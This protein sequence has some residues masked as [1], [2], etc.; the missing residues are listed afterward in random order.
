VHKS[1]SFTNDEM[2]GLDDAARDLRIDAL[3]FVTVLDS[4]LRLFRRGQY[5]PYRGTLV[6]LNTDRHIL[7]TRGSVW[8]YET[9]PGLYLPEP[10]ELRIVR[11]DESPSFLA[12]EV[13]GLTKLNWNNTQFD[14]KYPV[15]LG[16]ARKVGQVLK[17]LNENERTQS[18]YS[19][20]M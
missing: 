3:D 17:Y 11:S 6:S 1:S 20:Y 4:K 18:R 9:Y 12:S 10:I 5:P 13:L 15:T 7:Y 8:F 2:R 16:C 19:F 14:G